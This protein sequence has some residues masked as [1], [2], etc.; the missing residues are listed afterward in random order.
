M[1]RGKKVNPEKRSHAI[2]MDPSKGRRKKSP[3]KREAKKHVK[4]G[5]ATEKEKG[6]G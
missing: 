2:G 1:G 3:K 6:G 4:T 5:K